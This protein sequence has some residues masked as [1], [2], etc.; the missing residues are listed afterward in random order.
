M[1]KKK[2][3]IHT[4]IHYLMLYML[5]L[6]NGSRIW[7]VT[8]RRNGTFAYAIEM[9]IILIAIFCAVVKR[10]KYNFRYSWTE[11]L[12][13]LA[14]V[15]FV[16]FTS[17]GVGIAI[18][19][20]WA[21]YLL[22]THITIEYDSKY[23]MQRYVNIVYFIAGIS[24]IGFFLQIIQPQ[25]LQKILPAYESNFSTYAGM[26]G[27]T[28]LRKAQTAWGKFLFTFDE[29]QI[30][31]N[32]GIFSEPG[33][34]QIVLN[35]AIFILL[36]M[37][38]HLNFNRK[39]YNR[40]IVILIIAL[41]T[42]QSV[43]GYISLIILLFTYVVANQREKGT[44]ASRRIITVIT[45]VL[46]LAVI[47]DFGV[48]GDDSLTYR[49]F[50]Q[51]LF[52]EQGRIDLSVSSGLYRMGTIGTSVSLM[53]NNPLGIGYDSANATIQSAMAGSTGAII[54]ITGAALGIIPLLVIIYWI[55]SPVIKST[56]RSSIYLFPINFVVMV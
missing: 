15:I 44:S 19:L 6:A 42:S 53:I 47:I 54:L 26:S 49:L 28:V 9:A 30:T 24:L 29:R 45:F 13:L 5:L 8:A 7:V 27:M 21:A 34:Y 46:S 56:V 17:G 11:L 36:Y 18:I 14:F 52:N 41:I 35:A 1:G 4:T 51:R 16:R 50:L 3:K 10:K 20:E 38:E 33:V 37:K 48:R 12:V 2:I 39:Q 32:V 40:R 43:T 31:R 25:I 55:F 23:V 22:L